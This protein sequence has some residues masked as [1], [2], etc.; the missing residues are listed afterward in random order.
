MRSYSPQQAIKPILT[1]TL[2]ESV[3]SL[4]G[5]VLAA[6]CVQRRIHDMELGKLTLRHNL[7]IPLPIARITIRIGIVPETINMPSH[8]RSVRLK[9]TL[10]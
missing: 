3:L 4:R 6:G 8:R 1:K 7:T 9:H 2:S 10:R 5:L